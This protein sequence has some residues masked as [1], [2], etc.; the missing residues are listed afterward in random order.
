MDKI[1]QSH[2]RILRENKEWY[3]EFT[4]IKVTGNCDARRCESPATRWYGNTSLAT[5]GNISC[6][7]E[8][9]EQRRELE[10][11]MSENNDE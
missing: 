6:I 7:D 8:L 1:D 2:D 4:S 11:S 10:R 9:N 5:C 3:E